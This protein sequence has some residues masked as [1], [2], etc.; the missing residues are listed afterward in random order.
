MEGCHT[1]QA[2]GQSQKIDH[3]ETKCKGMQ[4]PTAQ[5]KNGTKAAGKEE[6]ALSETSDVELID[7]D[8]DEDQEMTQEIPEEDE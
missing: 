4:S 3:E 8:D 7:L 2:N 6:D 5:K 1:P